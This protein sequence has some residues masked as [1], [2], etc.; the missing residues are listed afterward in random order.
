MFSRVR[1]LTSSAFVLGSLTLTTVVACGG[2]VALDDIPI[3]VDGG[4]ASN[5][6]GGT[7]GTSGSGAGSSS[8]SG[9]STGTGATSPGNPGS[10]APSPGTAPTPTP[11]PPKPIVIDCGDK[12]CDG[13]AQSCCVTQDGEASCIAKGGKCA[14]VPFNCSNT[15]SC[16][17]TQVCCLDI[18]GGGGGGGGFGEASCVPKS[19]CDGNIGPGG[20]SVILCEN[21]NECPQGQRCRDAFGIGIKMCRARRGGGGGGGGPGGN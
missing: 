7:P 21:D 15:A 13:N 1:A 5:N 3:N 10:T 6:N 18:S 2:S 4:G 8:G 14:G 9:G 16:G 17:A 20:G 12:T 11:T 19:Q